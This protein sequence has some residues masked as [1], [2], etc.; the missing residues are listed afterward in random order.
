MTRND[1]MILFIAYI[2]GLLS[3]N[4]VPFSSSGFTGEQLCL[5]AVGLV[6]LAGVIGI[7]SVRQNVKTSYKLWLGVAIVAILAVVYFQLRIPQPNRNDISYQVTTSDSELVTVEGKVLTEPRL[8]DSQRLKFWLEA[9]EIDNDKQVS[10]KLYVTVPLLQGT[11]IYPGGNLKLKGILYLPQAASNPGGFDFKAY[12]ARQGIFAGMQGME[13]IF[14]DSS[15]PVW[16]WWKLRQRIVRSQLQGLGSPVGQ[17][18]SSMVL[19]RK[20]VDLPSDIRDRFIEAGLAHVLAASGF[21]VSLLLGIILKLTTRF[22]TKPRLVLGI[23]TLLVYLGLTGIQASVFRACLMGVAVLIALARSTKVKPLGSLLLAAIIILLF[24]PLLIG[25]LGFQLSFLATFGLIVTMPGLQARLD[26]LPPTIATLVAV[27]LAASIWV[28]PLLGY[29]FNTVATYSI[30]VNIFC[31]PLITVISLGGMV[32]A[33]A[34]LIIPALGSAIASLLF[35]PTTLLIAVTKLFTNFPGSSWAIGQISFGLLLAIYGLFLL[36]W[37]HKWWSKRWWLAL[38]FALTL[39]IVPIGYNH[40]NLTQVNVLATQSEPVIVIQDRGKV[41]LINSGKPKTV[42]YTVL[43]FLTQQGIN[44]L[45]YAIDLNQKS[46]SDWIQISDRL[47]INYFIPHPNSVNQLTPISQKTVVQSLNQGIS[48]NSL[49]I[50]FENQLS[51]LKLETVT[52]TWLILS[53][54][55]RDPKQ[56]RQYIQQSNLNHKPFVLVGSTI[57]PAWLEFQPQTIISSEQLKKIRRQN[58]SQNISNIRSYNLKQD[59]A[60]SWTPKHG[61]RTLASPDFFTLNHNS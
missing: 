34:S 52:E 26:W 25:D 23:G 44:H 24:N 28:L 14:N 19:G 2:V 18:V 57:D 47:S 4:L 42:K 46:N 36:V 50:S 58:I 59:G 31:T 9:T 17:L 40:L 1:W 43:P 39:I 51:L 60:I 13:V 49:S 45:D 30:L 27:P 53:K 61:F 10:G 32:S 22:A 33:I 6:G 29:A 11:G 3:T 55:Q 16:G 21:H 37:L 41:I 35:Y 48:S 15:Q 8:N 54:I 38:L 7:I 20:A 5:F 12:L 56:I